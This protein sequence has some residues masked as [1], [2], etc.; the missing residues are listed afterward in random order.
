MIQKTLALVAI[1]AMVLGVSKPAS[2]EID[3]TIEEFSQVTGW[4][5]ADYS[6]ALRMFLSTCPDMERQDWQNLC[7]LAVNQTNSELFFETVFRPVLMSVGTLGVFTGYFEPELDWD[8]Q[9]SKRLQ[10]PIYKA[11]LNLPKG[12]PWLNRRQIEAG[13]AL[14]NQDL[15]IVWVDDPVEL[16]FLQIQ[17]FGRALLPRGEVLRLGYGGFNRRPYKLLGAELGRRGIYDRHQVSAQF[18]QNWV[19]RH[20]IAGQSLLCYSPGYVF[21]REIPN[22]PAHKGLRGTMNRSLTPMLSLVDDPRFVPLGALAWLEKKGEKLPNRLMVAQDTGLASK[23]P[24]RGGISIATG[25]EA[26]R[27]VAKIKDRGRKLV[28]WSIQSAY[29]APLEQGR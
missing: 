9:P 14:A 13:N 28:L 23:K 10:Y 17:G 4:Q 1:L 16:L 19:Q 11:P 7:T 2:A 25:L 18:I 12:R 3:V 6:S 21:F 20:F 24:Q 26:G 22:L 29:A 15:E 27:S 8:L 5:E